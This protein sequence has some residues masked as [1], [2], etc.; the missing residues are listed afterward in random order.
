MGAFDDLIPR[1]KGGGAFDDLIPSPNASEGASVR[2][3]TS[4]VS[5]ALGEGALNIQAAAGNFLQ[6][7]AAN[8]LA[9]VKGAYSA[10][11]RGLAWLARQAG[12]EAEPYQEAV[13][14]AQQASQFAAEQRAKNVAA[15]DGSWLNPRTA[16]ARFGLG[17]Q[18]DARGRIQQIQHDNRATNPE[19]LRQQQAVADADGFVDTAVALKDNPLA[20]TYTLA[21]SL[22]DMGLGL[23]AARMAAAAPLRAAGPAA[24][25]AAA[26]A[27]A[28]GGDGAAA[29]QAAIEAAQAQAVGRASTAGMLS[30]ATSSGYNAREGTYQQVVGMPLDQLQASPRFRELV[31]QLHDPQRARE[32]LA[33]ELADQTSLLSAAGTAAGTLVTNRLFGGDATAETVAGVHKMGVR[34]LAKRVGQDT[35]EEVLQGLPEDTV[36]H[37]AVVQADPTHKLDLGGSVAQNAVAGVAMGSGGHG[38][39]F[40]AQRLGGSPAATDSSAP[41]PAG[42]APDLGNSPAPAAADNAAEEALLKPSSLTALDRV[43]QIDAEAQRAGERLAELSRPDAGYGPMFDQERQDLTAQYEQLLAE[44]ADLKKGWPAAVPGAPTSLSTE[45]GTRIDGTYA[46]MNADDLV[47]SHDVNLRQSANYPQEL[48]PRDR[49]RAA[50]EMQVS[51]IVQRIDPARLGASADAATGAPIVG[52]DGLV[53]SGNARTIA[54]KRIYQANGQKA[55][56][57]KQ[58]LR[59]NA[60]QF[61]ITPESVDTMAKPV[62]VRVRSTPVDRAEFARQANAPTVAQMSP[63]EQAKSDAQRID[64]MED[65]A[66]DDNGDFSGPASRDFIRR[67]MSRLPSTEQ[68]GMIDAN[69]ALSSIGYQRVRNAVLAKAYGDSPMLLR[70]VESMDDNLRNVSKALTIAAP[71]VAQMR[72]AVAQGSRHDADMTPDLMTS[73]EELSRL[74]DSGTSVT[75]ALAQL[76]MLGEKYS[77]ETRE[78]L[79]FLS[80]NARRPRR[81]ADFIVAYNEA[82][83]AAGDPNQGSLLDDGAPPAKADLM[84]AARRAIDGESTQ[85]PQRPDAGENPQPS[86]QTGSEPAA[87]PNDRGVDQGPGPAAAAAEPG[88]GR[89]EVGK[90]W[91]A[92]APELG[93]LGVPR[94]E[95]PQIKAEHRGALVQFL[96]ARGIDHQQEEVPADSLKPTQV[97]FSPE[98]VKKA[99]DFEGGDRSILVSQDNHVVDG[100]HQWLARGANGEPVKVIRLN[101]PIAQLLDQVRE[102]P[103]AEAADGA[104]PVTADQPDALVAEVQKVVDEIRAAWANA[105]EVVVV[106]NMQDEAVPVRVREVDAEQKSQG[107]AGEPEGFFHDGKVYLVAAELPTAADASRVLFHEALGHYGLRGVYGDALKPILSHLAMARPD[108]MKPKAKQYGLDLTVPAQRLQVAEEVLAEL[109]QSQPDL[110]FVKRAVAAVRTWLR[111]HVPGFKGL[112]LTDAEII[113]NYILPARGFVERGRDAGADGGVSFAR[114]FHG[115]P[116][117][118]IDKFSTEKIGSGEGAQAYGWGLY[119]ASKKEIAEHYRK[120]LSYREIVRQFRDALP[121]DADLDEALEAAQNGELS[122]PMADV[123]K[124]LAA[125]DWLGFDYP[126]Q[127]ITAAFKNM[128]DYDPSPALVEA[129]RDYGGQLYEVDIPDDSEMLLWDKPIADQPAKVRVAMEK[130]RQQVQSP[131]AEAGLAQMKPEDAAKHQGNANN[132]PGKVWYLRYARALGGEQAA[133]ESLA[134]LGIKGIKYLDGGSRAAGDGSH[135]YVVFDGDH[136]QIIDTMYSRKADPAKTAAERA[137]DIINDRVSR[138]A[139]LDVAAKFLVND[140]AHLPQAIDTSLKAAGLAIEKAMQMLPAGSQESLK[141]AMETIKAGVV[142]DYG[143]PES[144]IDQRAMLQGRQRVQLRQAGSLV[145][146]LSTLTRAESRV[147]YAWMNETDPQEAEALMKQLPETSVKVLQDVQQM[148]DRLSR[149]AV[150]MGQLSPEAYE[151]NKFAYLRRSYAKHVV[152]QPAG[153]KAQRSRTISILGDQYKGRGLTEAAPM[154]QIQNGAPD[155]WKRKLQEGKADTS[156]KGEKFIRLERHAASGEGTQALDGMEGKQRGRLEDVHYFPAGEPLPAK[157]SDWDQAGTWE[158]RDVKGGDAIMWRDFTKEE[159][160]T[161]GEVDEAR[162]AIAKTLHGMI[163]DVEIGRY[164]EW[165]AHNYAMK[166]EA[167]VP[168][169]VVEASERYKDTF[170][171]GEWV[172]VPDTKIPGTDVAKYGKLAGRYLQGPIW[173][174]LRQ[175]VNGQ[176]KPFGDT[177]AQ[178]MS[179]WKTAKTALSPAVHLNN[180]MSNFVM[181]DWHDVGAAHTAK[182]LRLILA[183]HKRDGKGVIGR[184]GN[185]LARAGIADREAALEVL[186][187]YKDSGGDIGGW[188]TNEIANEQLEPLLASLEQELA[189]SAGDSVQA[190]VGVMAALQHAVMLRFPSAWESFKGTKAGKAVTTEAKNLIEVYQSEDDIFRLAAWLKAKED[191]ATDLA[192]GKLSRQSFLD[193]RV[194]APWI[195]AMR[196]SAWPFISFTYRAVPLLLETA[197]KKPH[198]LMKLMALAGVLNALGVAMGGGGDDDERKLLPEEKAGRIWGMVP[199][200]IRMPWNDTNG[201]PV[202]LDIRRFIPVGDVLDVGQGHSAVPVL[203]GLQ[204]GG[205][206]VLAGELVLNRSAF[207]GKPITLDTDTAPQQAAKVADYLYKAFAPN[208]LGLPGT[209]ATQGVVDSVKGRT[210]PFGREQSVAQAVSSAFGLKLGSYPADV[211]RRNLHAKA[212]AE[213]TEIDR[214]IAQLKRQRQTNRL[215]QD[216][217]QDQVQVEQEKKVK[218]LREL[219]EK[220]SQ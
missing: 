150:Q 62:L 209:Y 178:V 116:H 130:F 55:E 84:T 34:D 70:M 217:F 171:P 184:T 187:R 11:D 6:A 205:P 96:K 3:Y 146:K 14:D 218:L 177:F 18:E 48:Q 21:R 198:K 24:E 33:N 183:A 176:F 104:T 206:L 110:G 126:A 92:F 54:L 157:Y 156:L 155:W 147:A 138:V 211:L 200:L 57:Y 170:K 32:V 202:Y 8:T 105:P 75:D 77:P 60:A 27:V 68:A 195:Q 189:A 111:E 63:S 37:G 214:N 149:E 122:K 108:L 83:D 49:D 16:I 51:G 167:A 113:K 88:A 10:V 74:K 151:R 53:E 71:R 118:G 61:G 134:G 182:A 97:E 124:A 44:S 160:E 76:D 87:A 12:G 123:V 52:A 141:S 199:K 128:D 65:L 5:N 164:L 169:Q 163:H 112:K 179:L 120:G 80:D 40:V 204:P 139:P 50:S 94:A 45:A 208:V 86:P 181:A 1:R 165:L 175:V 219:A 131:V 216:Q 35:V 43:Q 20:T 103:S 127:A 9:G 114:A 99:Q 4:A 162:F 38:A 73:V 107:A 142:S 90:G 102:F 42:A 59:D 28:V 180:V 140:V 148:V 78:I 39:G 23:G 109:A 19:L 72:E 136:V 133:S 192:A 196:N 201:S 159:R 81:M 89:E 213:A 220:L 190:Q 119:F 215:T 30:E 101:A 115:T 95:M 186:N 13:N 193:Y 188:A 91:Q 17:L 64:S 22:P 36:Q 121:D 41:A 166:A 135:N 207:T 161:M 7:P 152:E 210:D 25:A 212:Q 46:L 174:D 66:P 26:R 79:Q 58:F 173:N 69:G 82:L 47:S 31:A 197:A 137:E 145:E 153:A 117:R 172:K 143:V 85:D 191:G 154:K 93:T 2:D 56:V 194:N 98:K 203:P 100:H 168:G 144:V 15:D 158:V 129:V 29:A 67:F 132:W 106:P 125:D 185:A